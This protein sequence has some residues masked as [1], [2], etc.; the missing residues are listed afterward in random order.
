MSCRRLQRATTKENPRL[1]HHANRRQHRRIRRNPTAT[2]HETR[3]Y[4]N[5]I[6]GQASSAV[7]ITKLHISYQSTTSRPHLGTMRTP[8]NLRPTQPQQLQDY[9]QTPAGKYG[10]HRH[11]RSTPLALQS[12]RRWARKLDVTKSQE[13]TT[14]LWWLIGVHTL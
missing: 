4:R 7:R 11:K 2:H 14:R 3:W 12:S 10:T 1:P 13:L 5:R 6:Q 9:H 8:H